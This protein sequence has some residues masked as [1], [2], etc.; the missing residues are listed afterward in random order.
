M[1]ALEPTAPATDRP[2][3]RADLDGLRAVAVVLVMLS[4]AGGPWGNGGNAGV[5]AFF[6]L[7]GFLITG[8]LQAEL[9]RTGRIELMA[10]YRRR[11]RRLAPALLVLLAVVLPV[12]MLAGGS[13][14]RVLPIVGSLL[15]V[16][17]WLAVTGLNM[18][19]LPHTWSLAIEEQFY[20]LWPVALVVLKPR[21]A[22]VVALA[23]A[24]GSALTR[25]AAEGSFEYFSTLTRADAILVGSAL[26]LLGR[27]ALP[28]VA[29]VVG[30][31]A[32]VAISFSD[33]SH[34]AA[35]ALSIVAASGVVLS[36]LPALGWL[37]P[38][39][40]RAYSLYL[41]NWPL[42]LL[43]GPAGFFLTIPVAE[44]SY[45]IAERPFMRARPPMTRTVSTNDAPRSTDDA[46]TPRRRHVPTP[47]PVPWRNRPVA[48]VTAGV[49]AMFLVSSCAS[50]PPATP[51]ASATPVPCGGSSNDS[52]CVLVLGDSIAAGEGAAGVDRWPARLEAL[53]RQDLPGRHVL[54]S[55]WAQGG[56]QINL[57]E[58]R[59]A[60]LPLGSYAVAIVITG[61]NDT[62]VRPLDEW[63][64]RYEAAIKKLE[65]AGLTV[66]IGTS[67]PAL[68]GGVFTD[69]FKAVAEA[70]RAIA[71]TRP[72]LDLEKDWRDLGVPTA[73]GY[74]LDEVHQNAAGQ[75]VIAE[76]ARAV[77][78]P[79]LESSSSP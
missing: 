40:R 36:R 13:S 1:G 12:W 69:R 20:L 24:G 18:E 48:L 26:A 75:A 45:R 23:L 22:L 38:I 16:N 62:N 5:T 11:I 6:V 33:L 53:L 8:I 74:Y 76:R 79:I 66:V 47:A 59:V 17:N 51:T 56:S 14:E 15:Y 52:T 78:A 37:A 70:L 49:L 30:I 44:V 28:P 71:G 67:P 39:G 46:L 27:A 61:L 3:H 57:L 10:F 32:L 2:A 54:V 25:L 55:N 58:S 43:F 35:I 60:E 63:S 65:D 21:R 41:W 34:D 72:M 7:S 19:P 73:A 29:T 68:E 64:P 4:H 42:T 9:I 50:A 31:L 77:V